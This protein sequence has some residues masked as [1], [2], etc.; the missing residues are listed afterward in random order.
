MSFHLVLKR[1]RGVLESQFIR[2]TVD[3]NDLR[4]LLRD[5]ERIDMI[6][7]DGH[8]AWE[9]SSRACAVLQ[10]ERDQFR[11]LAKANAQALGDAMRELA[12]LV[13]ALKDARKSLF[14]KPACQAGAVQSCSCEACVLLR[15]DAALAAFTRQKGGEQC[16]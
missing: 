12:G 1:L 8:A 5:Y 9:R 4:E 7:R 14:Y 13:E 10:G 2:V 11:E 3:V 16:A 6:H 15:V